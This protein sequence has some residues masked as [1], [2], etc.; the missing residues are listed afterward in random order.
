MLRIDGVLEYDERLAAAIDGD[1]LLAPGEQEREI[2]ACAVH[3]AELLA[4]RL[5]VPSRILDLWLWNRGQAARYKS[6]P[7]PPNA[8]GLLLTLGRAWPGRRNHETACW[9]PP[10]G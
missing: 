1:Y 7:P 4:E 3:A 5:E 6:R 2:R 8:H 9:R 10:R